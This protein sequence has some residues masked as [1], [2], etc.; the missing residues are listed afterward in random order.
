MVC[1]PTLDG[2]LIQ[3]SYAISDY[4]CKILSRLDGKVALITGGARGVGLSMTKLFCKHGAK[5]VVTDIRDQLGQALQHEIGTEHATYVHCDVSKE[6][7]VAN[8]VNIAIS[9]YGKLD[10]M[11]N[12]AAITD[13]AK[14]S[15]LDN[16]VSDFEHVVRVNLVGPFLGTKH[17][18]RVMIP[19]KK[20]S[21]ITVGSVSS[22][23]G[24][25]SSHAYTSS[26][27]AIVGLAK[28]T[29]AELGE[30]GIRV[31]C[32]SCYCIHNALSKEFFKLDDEGFSR[33]YSNLKG[34]A[35]TEE[36]VAQAALYLASDESKYISGHNLAVDGGFTTIN[37]SFGLFSQF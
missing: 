12:N 36:D 17:A 29:A 25:V 30:F 11:V 34:V 23:V 18:A 33:V 19:A 10:I 2:F 35:L 13:D 16:D 1:S 24:G 8:A 20:G 28:N 21:I 26:K 14:L 7:D 9:K 22:S 5:L 27:H 15:I 3:T 6:I 31:N 32:L 4:C 37:P